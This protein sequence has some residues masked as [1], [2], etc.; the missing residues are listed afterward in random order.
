M[1][2]FLMKTLIRTIQF[3][4]FSKKTS[5]AKLNKALQVLIKSV[6]SYKQH[7][8]IKLHMLANFVSRICTKCNLINKKVLLLSSNNA[9]VKIL[10]VK[11]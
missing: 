1:L 5:T 9:S 11:R 6:Y 7:Y 4:E 8:K 3:Q 10:A 2:D